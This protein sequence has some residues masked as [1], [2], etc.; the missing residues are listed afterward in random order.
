MTAKTLLFAVLTT[1]ILTHKAIH[2]TA[3]AKAL[4]ARHLLLWTFSFFAQDL[5]LLTFFRSLFASFVS[6]GKRPKGFVRLV[7]SALLSVFAVYAIA[8]GFIGICFF[9]F[10]GSEVHYRNLGFVKDSSARA[11]LLAGF[12]TATL[13]SL[14]LYFVSWLWQNVIFTLFGLP[15][16]AVVLC[17]S[18][19]KGRRPRMPLHDK[20][21]DKCLFHYDELPSGSCSSHHHADQFYSP[22]M[23]WERG[24][25]MV[26]PTRTVQT[27]MACF[28]A[29]TVL[30][31]QAGF[32]FFRPPESAFTYLSWTSP[33][34]P[35]IDFDNSSPN[36]AKLPSV[37]GAGIGQSWDNITALGE[38]PHFSWLPG[39]TVLRGFE[40][41]YESRDHYR[42]AADPLRSVG[43][44]QPLIE[45]LSGHLEGVNIQHVMLIM[46]ESTRKDVF[47]IKK[48]ELI[49]NRFAKTFPDGN[50]PA[51]VA[52]R[53]ATL[54]PMAN[55]LTGDYDD[56]FNHTSKEIRGTKR[57][58]LNFQNA[59]T[60]AT[61]TKKSETGTLCGIHP[62]VADFNR[63][64]DHHIYQPCLPHIIEAFNHLD[65]DEDHYGNKYKDFASHKWRSSF[66]E[67][68]T[69]NYDHSGPLF[70]AFGFQDIISKEYLQQKSAKFGKVELPDINYFGMEETPL[71]DYI[72]DAFVK[73]KAQDER[74]FITHITST[75]HHPYKMPAN[76][77]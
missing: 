28:L 29:V 11:V 56:G 14:G 33:I 37:Y 32:L 9:A 46:L 75:S 71:R 60:A 73:A 77:T 21:I 50:L 69:I 66:M 36:L 30:L 26:S 38:P 40:D 31:T 25:T 34:L 19:A 65:V 41:W 20:D 63:E 48:N 54:T 68:T 13:T 12:L 1:T 24:Q 51:D 27:Y 47:P 5:Y 6:P 22:D 18:L 35:F 42:A 10:N 3:N 70:E 53:L 52:E 43:T 59:Y 55:H 45:G 4:P 7:A 44:Q 8:V 23:K 64:Y 67:S 61:Y 58:G 76:E 17:W 39:D 15:A 2:I 62:L 57:G 72:R 16:D 49:W 74:V